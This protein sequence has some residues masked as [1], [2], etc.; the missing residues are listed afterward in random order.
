MRFV[1]DDSALESR[2]NPRLQKKSQTLT[3]D[4]YAKPMP[5]RCRRWHAI[6]SGRTRSIMRRAVHQFCRVAR[7]PRFADDAAIVGGMARSMAN[8]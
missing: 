7:R 5:G 3:K 2:G 1:Q 8:R 6:H 4:I